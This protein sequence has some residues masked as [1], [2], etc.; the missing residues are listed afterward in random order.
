MKTP[1]GTSSCLGHNNGHLCKLSLADPSCRH[2]TEEHHTTQL[3]FERVQVGFF[4]QYISR[5]VCASTQSDQ[6]QH[7]S[8]IA[9]TGL[10]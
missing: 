9:N 1:L 3:L 5:S 4:E 10:L 6:D 2:A 8:Y 7:G